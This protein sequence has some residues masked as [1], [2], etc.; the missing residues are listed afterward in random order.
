MDFTLAASLRNIYP[1]EHMRLRCWQ[2]AWL[3]LSNV[4]KACVLHARIWVFRA[5][6][7]GASH[8]AQGLPNNSGLLSS[9]AV[10][11]RF[12]KLFYLSGASGGSL[13]GVQV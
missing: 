5:K 8:F 2:R 12:G 13:H 10:S 7:F 4:L 1:K 3:L 11:Q 6:P 9:D